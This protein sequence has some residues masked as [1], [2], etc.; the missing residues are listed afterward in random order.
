MVAIAIGKN[1]GVQELKDG[2]SVVNVSP[3][4]ISDKPMPEFGQSSITILI[5]Q[6]IAIKLF[7]IN[8][9]SS[10]Y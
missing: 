3:R 6:V 2:F 1:K 5:N 8:T 7:M 9:C 10:C 4:D